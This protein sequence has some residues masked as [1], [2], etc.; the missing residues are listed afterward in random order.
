MKTL[1][2]RLLE[3][4]IFEER[5][6]TQLTR[7]LN[8]SLLAGV[9]MSLLAAAV[10]G[11][12]SANPIPRITIYVILILVFLDPYFLLRQGHIHLASRILIY[13]LWLVITILI[14]ASGGVTSPN[15]V[16]LILVMFVAG[17]LVGGRY[18]ARRYR[19]S[20]G[21]ERWSHPS[22][23]LGT[24]KFRRLWAVRTSLL[25]AQVTWCR[26]WSALSPAAGRNVSM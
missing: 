9:I 17:M 3:P 15:M 2:Q 23:Q 16:G 10:S 24:I 21:N 22:S 13:P 5:D 20:A 25:R 6:K 26:P 8:I 18:V 1:V 11:L 14:F 12:I 7:L 4:P 19:W